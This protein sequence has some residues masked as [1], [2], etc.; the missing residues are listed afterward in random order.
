MPTREPSPRDTTFDLVSCRDMLGKLNREISRAC[1]AVLREDTA[2]HCTNAAWTAWHLA[3]WV[4]ADIKY[5][6][7]LKAE[8]A[9]EA[10][11]RGRRF[12]YSDFIDFVQSEGQCPELVHLRIITVT[13]KHVGAGPY[14]DLAFV[15]DAT[16][17][18]NIAFMVF[19][20]FMLQGLAIVHWLRGEAVLPA[21]AVVGVYVLLPFLQ[22]LLVMVLA[23]IGYTYAWFDFRR[24]FKK[25]KG[26]KT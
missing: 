19:V 9:R 6:E 21:F 22:V 15:I 13:S 16:W 26:S 3:E 11:V 12:K 7:V 20:M 4:W 10:G 18:Q 17:L 14:D 2:D 5:D 8:L 25:R 23:L 1:A 24:R